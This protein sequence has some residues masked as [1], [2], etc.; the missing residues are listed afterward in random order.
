[1][2]AIITDLDRTL[3]HTDKTLSSYSVDILQK[4]RDRGI[5]VMAATAR[6]L[7]SIQIYD[8]ILHFQA[9]TTMNG[10]RIILPNKILENGIPHPSA[11][12]ILSQIIT[13][14]DV[15]ISVETADGLFSNTEIPEWNTKLFADFPALPSTGTLYKILVS[16]IL[17]EQIENSLTEDTYYTIADSSLVQIMSKKSTKWNGIQVMLEFLGISPED[18]VY[19]GDDYDDIQP[20]QMCGTGVAVSNAIPDV[21]HQADD[22]AFSNDEDGVARYIEEHI[23]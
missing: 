8:D 15:V 19:F 20:I 23:L 13:I 22:I 7:R 18:A 14:P 17:P 1:M 4:C 21:L 11:K 9:V 12:Q 2:K 10:A 3:L 5:P 6:P 16:N